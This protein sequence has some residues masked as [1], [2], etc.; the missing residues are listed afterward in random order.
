MDL[1]RTF[2]MNLE[3][4]RRQR[5]LSQEELALEAGINR[6]YISDL[7]TAGIKKR[8]TPASLKKKRKDDGKGPYVGLEIIGKLADVLGVEGAD[9]LKKAKPTSPKR[10]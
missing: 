5:G 2:A 6:T 8:I 4:L 9:L 3:R 10:K 7:E 1:R